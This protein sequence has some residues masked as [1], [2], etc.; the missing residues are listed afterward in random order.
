V[1][2]LELIIVNEVSAVAEAIEAVRTL[3]ARRGVPSSVVPTLQLVLDDLLINVVSYAWHD[4][5]RH[6]A[7]L[8][9]AF[10]PQAVTLEISDDGIAFDPVAAPTPDVTLDLDEREV[11][12]LGIHLVRALVDVVDYSRTGERNVLTVTKKW[13][14]DL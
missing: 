14:V 5:E 7:T 9:V 13:D 11:G 3:A 10:S 12:G 2:D 4:G 1:W 6:A 8:R